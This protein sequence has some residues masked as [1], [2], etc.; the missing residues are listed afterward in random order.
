[1]RLVKSHHANAAKQWKNDC[2]GS[3]R[4][5]FTLV[6]LL[7]VIGIIALLISI[8][9]PSLQKA[10]RAA[11]TVQC[12]SN[13]RQVSMA[14]LMYINANKGVLPPTA[15]PMLAAYPNNYPFGFWWANE[16]VRGKYIK[17]NSVYTAPDPS[18]NTNNKKFY[19]P[20]VFKCPEGTSESDM[21]GGQGNFP[22]DALNN[23]CASAPSFGNDGWG[24]K[25]GFFIASW[26]QL[27]GRVC[28]NQSSGMSYP[29]GTSPSPFV[30]WN[31]GNS[32]WD[33]SD[34]INY[35]GVL[36]FRRTLSMV[37][38]S[39]EV[40]MIVEAAD[41]NWYDDVSHGPDG[42]Q[43]C[44][45]MGA[46]HG[47]KTADGYNAFTNFAFFDGHVALYPTLDYQSPVAGLG[48]YDQIHKQGTIFVLNQQR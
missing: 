25:E 30:W 12:S 20:N 28:D 1:M 2:A 48:L 36:R 42:K 27:N 19:G 21:T 7:V 32:T 23:G 44:R 16:L 9:L 39:A 5:A 29:G 40:V 45:R 46:R 47:K 41:P 15:M 26:Y 6:E 17:A 8:L 13:M 34:P 10:K 35:I 38:K 37:R 31:T 22:C 3:P 18:G 43:H 11:A 24:A 4:G 33:S 14:M